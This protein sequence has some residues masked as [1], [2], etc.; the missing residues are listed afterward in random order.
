MKINFMGN[1]GK[2]AQL[3]K[4]QNGDH[5]DSVLSVWVAENHKRR[6]GSTRT[7]WHKVTI[8]RGYAESMEKYL[9]KGRQVF[10]EGTGKGSFYTDKNNTIVPFIDVQAEKITLLD[11]KPDDD[12]PPEIDQETGEVVAQPAVAVETAQDETAM[13]L[14]W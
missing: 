13:D 1:I 5:Q 8:W 2:D 11:H 10:V 3:R 4:V 12:V 14:P 6:D 7:E 9:K